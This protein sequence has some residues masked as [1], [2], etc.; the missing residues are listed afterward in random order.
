MDLSSFFILVIIV[1]EVLENNRI[2]CFKMYTTLASVF[3][4]RSAKNLL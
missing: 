4:V 1:L 3:Y 2:G